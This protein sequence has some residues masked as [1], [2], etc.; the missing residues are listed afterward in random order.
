MSMV[1]I[2]LFGSLLKALKRNTCLIMAGDCD[3]L[4]SVG[5]GNVLRDILSGSAIP[6]VR[7]N[8]VFRQASE[9]RI[10]TN[11]H[12]INSGLMPLGNDSKTDFFFMNRTPDAAL[13]TIC[14]LCCGRLGKA[15]GF[16]SI[17]DIQ[18][19]SPSRKGIVGTINLNRVLQSRLNPPSQ[20]KKEKKFG[21][22]KH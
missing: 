5:A 8:E 14:E 11:A 17:S 22:E 10:V 13:E 12:R 16:D 2:V 9:S 15:Y 7:L 21:N 3:Q 20:G 18:V 1:D 19:L 4:P 6:A